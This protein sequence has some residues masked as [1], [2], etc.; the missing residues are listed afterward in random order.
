MLY[1]K[2]LWHI[3]I[4]W[5]FS[6]LGFTFFSKSPFIWLVGWFRRIIV[7][8]YYQSSDQSATGAGYQR[9][10]FVRRKAQHPSIIISSGS[11]VDGCQAS[12]GW[13]TGLLQLSTRPHALNGT[14]G[15]AA[16][17]K[18]LT[19]SLC[20]WSGYIGGGQCLLYTKAPFGRRKNSLIWSITV[21]PLSV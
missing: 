15:R 17:P 1:L 18:G 21:V 3:F 11:R 5:A 7:F 6:W 14:Q 12:R 13:W 10:V 2:E 16:F 8:F 19:L 9:C 4:T 20:L